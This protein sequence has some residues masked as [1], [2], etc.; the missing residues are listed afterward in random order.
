VIEVLLDTNVLASGFLG[1]KRPASVPGELLRRWGDGGFTLV[2]SDHIL[3]ELSRTLSDRYFTQRM[4][5]SELEAAISDLRTHAKLQPITVHVQG[6][7]TQ[8][9]DDL[10]LATALSAGATYLV[11]G[12]RPLQTVAHYQGITILSPRQFLG[13]L[14]SN[15]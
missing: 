9:K 1:L 4:T 8:P 3:T 5:A 6:V 12:D 14:E 15:P 2:V 10:I 13:V 7:A 11:T